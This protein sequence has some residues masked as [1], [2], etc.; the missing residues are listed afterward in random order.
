MLREPERS[1]T[2]DPHRLERSAPPREP[3]VVGGE[4]RRSGIDEPASRDGDGEERVAAHADASGGL[5]PALDRPGTVV[6]RR[7]VGREVT[8]SSD[9]HGRARRGAGASGC[10]DPGRT[11][12]TKQRIGLEPR[13][14]DL[15]LRVGV[16]DHAAADPEVDASRL[17]SQTCGSST[18]GRD[19]R[20]RR[21]DRAPPSR[22]RGRPARAARS[23]RPRR[24]WGH[25]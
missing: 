4:H 19:H 14:R 24:S 20:C 23:G 16:P 1:A 6:L 15:L 8:C 21:R 17:R 10:C 18:P 12:R 9:A 7:A 2:V 25:R 5:A 22:R 11:D 13:L 3:F